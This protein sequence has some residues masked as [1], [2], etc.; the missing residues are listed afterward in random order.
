MRIFLIFLLLTL[1]SI[2]LAQ[3]ERSLIYPSKDFSGKYFQKVKIKYQGN[4]PKKI[5]FGHEKLGFFKIRSFEIHKDEINFQF[6]PPSFKIP[7]HIK[8]DG[9]TILIKKFNSPFP[10]LFNF[11][12]PEIHGDMP[13]G[14]YVFQVW[15]Q[16]SLKQPINVTFVM[17]KF[18]EIL[19]AYTPFSLKN[20]TKFSRIKQAP[21]QSLWQIVGQPNQELRKINFNGDIIE[22]YPLPERFSFHHDFSFTDKNICLITRETNQIFDQGFFEKKANNSLEILS[23]NKI[24][25]KTFVLLCLDQRTK[26][27]KSVYRAK[28]HLSTYGLNGLSHDKE[29]IKSAL[30]WKEKEVD[31]NHANSIQNTKQGFLIN[32]RNSRSILLL[33]KN[34]FEKKWKLGMDKYADLRLSP[35]SF[36]S[37]HSAYMA[38]EKEILLFDNKGGLC[39][40]VLSIDFDKLSSKTIDQDCEY[41]ATR[42]GK[43]LKANETILV[44][45]PHFSDTSL[46]RIPTKLKLKAIE[47]EK[48]AALILNTKSIGFNGTFEF[49][50]ALDHEKN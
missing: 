24:P 32:L 49:W 42:R 14:F 26:K 9:K 5:T 38:N 30:N 6:I 25:L 7:I 36:R 40:R 1:S 2:S 23:L 39:P 15:T 45:Y 19:W 13:I 37:Q 41:Q 48:R 3:I 18:A 33:N 10:E 16:T 43:V 4:P 29:K 28:N 50:E 47:E 21:D 12:S 8:F 22:S 11:I 27:F 46:G 35:E 17:N 34:N 31:L 20:V 44:F